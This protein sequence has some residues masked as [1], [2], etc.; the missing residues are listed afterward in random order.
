MQ[1]GVRPVLSGASGIPFAAVS[2]SCLRGS[3]EKIS[4]RFR[5]FFALG[6]WLCVPLA[7]FGGQGHLARN[8]AGTSTDSCAGRFYAGGPR[9][10]AFFLEMDSQRQIL[11]GLEP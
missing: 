10:H 5:R 11:V 7:A 3:C 2:G 9:G 4:S 6:S 1:F 8:V